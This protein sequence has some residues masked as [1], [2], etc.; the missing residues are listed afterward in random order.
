MHVALVR[1]ANPSPLTLG[2]TNTWVV[3]R[4]PA[5]V[6]DPGPALPAHVQAVAAAVAAAGGAGGIVLTH[7]HPDHSEATEPL[8]DRLGG[9]PVAAMRHPADMRLRDGD[10]VGPFT[11]LHL[12]G[13]APDHAVL[14]LARTA[15][16][17]GDAVL[18]E[19]SVFVSA[20]GGGLAAYLDGLR[21]L[22][23]LGLAR[24]YPGHGPV[25]EDPAA[26]LDEY[27]AHRQD[28]ERRLVAALAEGART[29]AALLDAAWSDAPA[30]LR[31]A[32][33]LTLRAH[34]AKLRDEGRAPGDLRLD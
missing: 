18:G 10:R 25:I 26:K 21:R 7:D 19:G 1:A 30:A 5:W 14:V 20:D 8:R 2:G 32:A 24:L 6:V 16:F 11:V 9:P 4:D 33:A 15:A 28:R 13:H 27:V 29:E 34:L 22:R 12:P 17:T 23:A 31:P 3:G